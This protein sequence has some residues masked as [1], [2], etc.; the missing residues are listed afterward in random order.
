M[1]PAPVSHPPREFRHK[2]NITFNDNDT[3]SFREH[4][5]FRFQPDRSRGSESDYIMMPNILVM[6]SRG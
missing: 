1:T 6:V 3:V 5:S 4:R 2:T